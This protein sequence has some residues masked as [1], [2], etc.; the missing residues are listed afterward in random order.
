M[1]RARTAAVAALV[2]ILALGATA[3]AAPGVPPAV[4]SAQAVVAW[5]PSTGL[6]IAEI[7]TGGASASDEY[8]ELANASSAAIDLAGL[9]VAYVTSTG[10]T[11]TRK[12]T[13]PATLAARAGTAPADR[14]LERHLRR[15]G[16]CDVLGRVRGDR[17]RAGRAAR[18][19][20]GRSTRSGG[21]TRRARSS[22]GPRRRRRRPGARSSGGPAAP[23]ATS[24]DTNDNA[25]DFIVNGAP[26]GP[27]PGGRARAFRDAERLAVADAVAGSHADPGGVADADRHRRRRPRVATPTPTPS[28]T[29]T[30]TALADTDPDRRPRARRRSSSPRPTPTPAA[31]P[32]P[33]A[34]P[35]A[36]PSPPTPT[37]AAARL[38]RHRL[39]RDG[40]WRGRRGGRAPRDARRSS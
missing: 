16:R 35:T 13:W 25:A 37:I 5:P 22:R 9:E 15:R 7:V 19:R 38:G 39:D 26:V 29:P 3:L 33:T 12:A 23:A 27:E 32:S 8:V 10:G 36:S 20:P 34:V 31:T 6:V 17:W 11:V 21:A 4:V 40:P 24:V 1:A 14:E 30:P 2:L 28:P 18:R